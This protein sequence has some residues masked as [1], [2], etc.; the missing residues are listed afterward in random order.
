MLAVLMTA[1][2]VV[3]VPFFLICIYGFLGDLRRRRSK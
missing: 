1:I 2:L 3:G